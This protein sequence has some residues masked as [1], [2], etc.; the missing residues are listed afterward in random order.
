MRVSIV[1]TA[2]DGETPDSKSITN[3]VHRIH[4]RAAG[5]TEDVQKNVDMP[6]IPDIGYIQGATALKLNNEV[7]ENQSPII[8]TNQENIINKDEDLVSGVSLENASYFENDLNQEQNNTKEELEETIIDEISL[9][10]EKA[11]ES[12]NPNTQDEASPQLFS[13]EVSSTTSSE[14][15][16]DEHLR[17]EEEE[18]FE[19]PAFLRKQKI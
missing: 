7:E 16:I 17:N 11:K 3:N 4:T 1:A 13:D 12:P 9:F 2:L 14:S 8:N 18:D 19:I 5:Y 6:T 15:N 10:E